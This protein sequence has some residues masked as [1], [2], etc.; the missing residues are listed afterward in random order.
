MYDM[1]NNKIKDGEGKTLTITLDAET[2]AMLE[3]IRKVRFYDMPA[4]TTLAAGILKLAIR[5]Y[6]KLI[7]L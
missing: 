4:T 2:L 1:R 5:N 7:R 6:D 3:Q